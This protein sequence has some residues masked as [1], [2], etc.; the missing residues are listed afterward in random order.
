MGQV[1]LDQGRP[2]TGIDQVIKADPRDILGLEKVEDGRYFTDVE[3]VDRKSHPHLDAG[4][5]A[6]ANTFQ[7]FPIRAGNPSEAVIDVF[8]PVEADAHVGKSNVF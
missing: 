8:H 3:T 4:F 1:V 6:V 5:L 2:S 7:G